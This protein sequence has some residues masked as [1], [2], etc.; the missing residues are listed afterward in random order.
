MNLKQKRKAKQMTQAEVAKAVGIKRLRYWTYE[1]GKRKPRPE[2]AMKI[3]DVLDFN[4]SE[5]YTR[6]ADDAEADDAGRV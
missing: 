2:I 1:S 4:W 5:F 3:A 6:E